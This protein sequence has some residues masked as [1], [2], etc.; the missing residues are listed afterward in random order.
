LSCFSDWQ[1]GYSFALSSAA[2]ILNVITPFLALIPH[3]PAAMITEMQRNKNEIDSIEFD[4]NQFEYIS[5]DGHLLEFNFVC[6][7]N[8]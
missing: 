7:V 5:F 2:W 4:M 6:F 8:R 1:Y 3:V